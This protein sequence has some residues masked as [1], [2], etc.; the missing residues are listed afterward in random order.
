MRHGVPPWRPGGAFALLVRLDPPY[1][2]KP[3]YQRSAADEEA[4]NRADPGRAAFAAD[5]DA[6]AAVVAER[7]FAS[8][9]AAI[10]AADPNHLLLG[11]RF[12]YIPAPA[13]IAA[14]ARHVDAISF[15]CYE[16]DAS[17]AID[18]YAAI[19]K[20]IL[21]GEFSFRSA[22]SGL[23]NSRG[24]G[25]LVATQA[26]RAACFRHYVS[27]AVRKPGI[28]GYHWFE[29]ADQP[30]EGRLDGENSNFGTVTIEDRVYKELTQ[31]MMSVNAAAEQL[32]AS[33]GRR[34]A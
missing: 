17:D 18:T 22:D 8:T 13:V 7:Y 5:C 26:E 1:R 11:C 29:H 3:P 4:A 24:A 30:A 25:P 15:N 34:A 10:K 32:H 31:T 28:V 23:P 9:C 33:A 2:R 27:T 21:I 6:F 19:G 20:P 16:F 14:S 12:A